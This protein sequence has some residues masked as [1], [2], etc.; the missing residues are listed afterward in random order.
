MILSDLSQRTKAKPAP[1]EHNSALR[2]LTTNT[3]ISIANATV[4]TTVNIT[5]IILSKREINKNAQGG[6][7][8]DKFIHPG[9]DHSLY[10]SIDRLIHM[11]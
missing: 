7:T 9:G 5:D 1:P 4:A 11:D 2:K 10:S 6:V 3:G 8:F